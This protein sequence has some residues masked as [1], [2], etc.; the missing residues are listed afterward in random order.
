MQP[1]TPFFSGKSTKILL[2]VFVFLIGL[3]GYLFYQYWKIEKKTIQEIDNSGVN[4]IAVVS[5]P[6]DIL[7]QEEKIS[8]GY[9]QMGSN[10]AFAGYVIEKGNNFFVLVDEEIKV[11]IEITPETIFILPLGDP[12]NPDK[13]LPKEKMPPLSIENIEIGDFIDVILGKEIEED[14]YQGGLVLID[15]KE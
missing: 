15:K 2:A 13:I 4:N 11:K 1:E 10:R 12:D 8:L 9:R 5:P 3:N 7:A 14:E 6:Q